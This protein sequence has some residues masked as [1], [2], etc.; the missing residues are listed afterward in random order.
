MRIE[1][2]KASKPEADKLIQEIKHLVKVKGLDVDIVSHKGAD[3]QDPVMASGCDSCTVCPCM[4]C[5]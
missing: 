1:K 3:I 4:I 5:W 2:G